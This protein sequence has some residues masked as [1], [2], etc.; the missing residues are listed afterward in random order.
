M[1]RV[2]TLGAGCFWGPQKFFDQHHGIL[3]TTVGYAN[4]QEKHIS[5]PQVCSGTT[6]FVEA[7][8]IVFDDKQISLTRI[9]EDFFGS[10]DPTLL[11]RQGPDWG[12]QYRTG[13]YYQPKDE[14]EFLPLIKHQ[15][16]KEQQKYSDKIVTE[17]EPLCNFVPAEEY[18]QKYLEKNPNRQCHFGWRKK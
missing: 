12:R 3:K 18:H 17:V 14:K 8:E 10:I 1:K 6:D 11:N 4:G 16:L 13:I 2:I 15:V 5:Y 7:V 9:L